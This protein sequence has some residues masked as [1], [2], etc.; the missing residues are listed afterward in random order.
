MDGGAVG[1]ILYQR[2]TGGVG[3]IPGRSAVGKDASS[4][5]YV[6]VLAT[7]GGPHRHTRLHTF[8]SEIGSTSL[9]LRSA[10]SHHVEGGER[11]SL[12]E[13]PGSVDFVDLRS[14]NDYFALKTEGGIY[15]GTLERNTAAAGGGITDAGLL[16]YEVTTTNAR[17]GG[18]AVSATAI[19]LTP[20]H[21]VTLNSANEV[22]FVN[23]VARKVIQ[24]ERVDW[25]S[26]SQSASSDEFGSGGQA[27]LLMDI[28]RPDQIWLRKGRS[29]VHISSSCEDRDIWKYTLM[30][31]IE[32]T[33]TGH[34]NMPPSSN[35]D[36]SNT[37]SPSAT[38]TLEEKQVDSQFELAKSLC[39]NAQQ[40]AVVNA[41]RAEYHL[42]QGR[43]ELGAKFLA[44]CPTALM[45]FADTAA[46]LALP[47]LGL[48]EI[49]SRRNSTKA[50]AALASSNMSLITFLSEKMKNP[51][52]REDSSVSTIFGAWVTELYMHEREKEGLSNE[53][54][55][56][57]SSRQFQSANPAIL[58]QFLSS[59][60]R[61]MDARTIISVLASHDITA[62]ECAGYSA[63]AGDLGA[64]VDAALCSDDVKNGALDALRVL[65]DSPIEKAEHYYYKHAL[66]LLSR[67]PMASSKSFLNRYSEGLSESMLL[68][69]M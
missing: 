26:I 23:R 8:R 42:S 64:A 37:L 27:E 1:G 45:P 67:A 51:Q 38:L 60:V 46:R 29:L 69:S 30:K 44:Q 12:I 66:T 7:T 53:G 56:S 4:S 35:A 62:R 68:P 65:N 43:A 33:S 63:A 24:Q 54:Y 48:D 16:P 13:L 58:H 6:I 21:F 57:A 59:H 32:T 39:S 34:S 18:T 19:G 2:I 10:F 61:D 15:Y 49:H 17:K 5:G 50:N 36:E 22:K 25:M 41:V 31:C 20:Y 14:C 11:V 28:R 55:F 40:K 52:S 9:T 47:M 3:G